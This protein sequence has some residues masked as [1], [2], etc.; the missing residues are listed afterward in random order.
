MARSEYRKRRNPHAILSPTRAGAGARLAVPGSE[1][2]IVS[3][4]FQRVAAL[5]AISGLV[6]ACSSP[7]G[8]GGAQTVD[9]TVKE[10]EITLASSS[11]NAGSI[12]INVTNDGDKQHEFII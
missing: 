8:S 10:W 11:F 5:L 12:T 4:S 6:A 9:A 1:A 3:K 2:E 7:G